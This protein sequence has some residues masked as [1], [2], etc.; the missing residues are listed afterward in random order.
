[1]GFVATAPDVTL[2]FTDNGAGRDLVVRVDG[3][4]DTLMLINDAAG[5]W[6]F[7]DDHE[8]I[9]PLIRLSAASEGIYDIWVGTF[10]GDLCDATLILETF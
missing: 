1:M 2:N 10:G 8:G 7:N 5:G 9:D 6:H 4:C 3:T